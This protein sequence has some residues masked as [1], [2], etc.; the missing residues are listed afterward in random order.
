MKYAELLY[1]RKTAHNYLVAT[2]RDQIQN[3]PAEPQQNLVHVGFA[4]LYLSVAAAAAADD[5][6]S[7]A[8]NTKYNH[9]LD[10]SS[11]NHNNNLSVA[12]VH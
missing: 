2:M 10:H 12:A 3:Q 1:D 8:N 7:F 5:D 11:W 4:L 6:A 9:R